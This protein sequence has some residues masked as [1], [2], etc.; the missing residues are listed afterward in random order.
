MK[1]KKITYDTVQEAC[2]KLG[3]VGLENRIIVKKKYLALS[4]KYHPDMT[5]GSTKKF[6]EIN[7]A[8]KI[9]EY[10]IDHFHFH[11]TKEEFLEQ[12]PHAFMDDPEWFK[13][14]H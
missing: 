8:Y 3:L 4:K 12:Y 2:K 14:K 6:Q 5:D 11:F 9:I 13:R 7:E 10:Y 1:R